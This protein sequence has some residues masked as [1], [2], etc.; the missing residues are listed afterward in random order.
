MQAQRKVC[1]NQIHNILSNNNYQK[2]LAIFVGVVSMID[3]VLNDTSA[4]FSVVIVRKG[5]AMTMRS[6]RSS[7]DG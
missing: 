5:G 1:E 3:F 2:L 6:L 4:K 7:D